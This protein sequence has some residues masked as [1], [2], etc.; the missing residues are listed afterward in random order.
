MT[1]TGAATPG[2]SP[3]AP[4]VD[5]LAAL[6][7]WSAFS[8]RTL[9]GLVSRQFRRGELLDVCVSVGVNSVGVV[10]VTGTFIVMVLAVQ[11]YS[12]FHQIG[13]ETSLGAAI[14][15]SVVRELGPVLTAFMLAG[16]IGSAMAA[17]LGTMKVTEQL[18]ALACLGVDPVRYLVAPRFVASLVMIPL[19]TVFA[20]LMGLFG[21]SAICLK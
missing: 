8:A 18:D 21:S 10:A 13:M 15:L 16:R 11:A 19:L 2:R 5:A 7:D 12:Q 14:H 6:G 4:V 9:S 17:Q 20:D 3:F 1:A